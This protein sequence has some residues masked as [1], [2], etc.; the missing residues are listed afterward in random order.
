MLL[1]IK[2][3]QEDGHSWPSVFIVVGDK[4]NEDR[5]A[6]VPILHYFGA[7]P[8]QK[9]GAHSRVRRRTGSEIVAFVV[10]VCSRVA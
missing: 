2:W 5:R 6:R 9:A 7:E 3:N 10:R 1:L 4:T 8:F